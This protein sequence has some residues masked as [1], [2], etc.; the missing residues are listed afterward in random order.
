MGND[1]LVT[2]LILC[3]NFSLSFLI[4]SFILPEWPQLKENLMFPPLCNLESFRASACERE[5]VHSLC[6]WSLIT[7]HRFKSPFCFSHSACS[8]HRVKK[9]IAFF[10]WYFFFCD[11]STVHHKY[12]EVMWASSQSSRSAALF[13]WV[14]WKCKCFW[15]KVV[16]V[17][18][19]CILFIWSIRTGETVARA[20]TQ[21]HFCQI[22]WYPFNSC[23]QRCDHWWYLK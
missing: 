7:P 17:L 9:K 11:I 21:S 2:F 15:I 23:F 10:L 12:C 1:N 6:A 14:Q 4:R 16:Y 18:C 22:E 5:L 13:T 20:Q 3:S 8:N 19:G